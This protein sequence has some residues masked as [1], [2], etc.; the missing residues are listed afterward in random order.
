MTAR[1]LPAATVVEA[2]AALDEAGIRWVLLRG[3]QGLGEEGRDVDLLVDADDLVSLE[4]TLYGLGAVALPR[5]MHPWHRFYVLGGMRPGRGVKLDVVTELIYCR[6]APIRSGLEAV[7]LDRRRS[8]DGIYVLDPTDMF[9]TVLLHCV[10]DKQHISERRRAELVAVVDEVSRPCQGEQLFERLCP[11]G[12]SAARALESVRSEDWEAL[13]RL[14][15]QLGQPAPAAAHRRRE[16]RVGRPARGARAAAGSIYPALWRANRW[17]REGWR[18]LS[19][20]GV[21]QMRSVRSFVADTPPPGQVRVSFSGLD[22]AGKTRQID[23]L[24]AAVEDTHSVD[25]LWI[26]FRIWPESL[27]NRL[28]ASFRSRL[29]PKRRTT[30]SDKNVLESASRHSEAG[31]SLVWTAV[32]TFAAISAGLSLRRRAAASRAELLVLDRYRLDTIVKLQY[33]YA[34][35]PAAWLARVVGF[36]A[37]APDVEFL[38]RVEPEVAHRRKPEQWSVSELS[39][40]ARLYN[41]LGTGAFPVVTLDGHQPSDEIARQVRSRVRAILNDS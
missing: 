40:Q 4:K 17:S 15:Q 16:W 11:P 24:V 26:P 27:L 7:C 13:A 36:I 33:W 2:L 12:W 9:W 21:A 35:V 32:G 3:A 34:D 23:S 6:S 31:R 19:E 37:P 22:G 14:G 29:G 5:R 8:R 39:R 38:L 30:S 20:R 1:R 41:Q 18:R 25:V 28:P 10:L